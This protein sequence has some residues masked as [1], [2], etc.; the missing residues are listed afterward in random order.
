M[1]IFS[2]TVMED[3]ERLKLNNWLIFQATA[4]GIFMLASTVTGFSTPSM[5]PDTI[6]VNIPAASSQVNKKEEIKKTIS[7]EQYVRTYFSDVP[8]MIEVARCESRFRQ[9]DKSGSVL[10]GEQNSLD[11]GVM[12]INR[13]YHDDEAEALGYDLHTLEGNTAYARYLFEKFGAKPWKSSSPCWSKTAAYQDYVLSA[14]LAL[15]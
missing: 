13:Y 15:K 7:V 9:Y 1:N 5:Q 10:K 11:R 8:I 14:N 4:F 2:M 3:G 6:E 12:Q